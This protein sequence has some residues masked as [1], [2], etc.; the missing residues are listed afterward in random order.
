MLK[1]VCLNLQEAKDTHDLA[2]RHPR[3]RLEQIEEPR[4]VLLQVQL[5]LE[6]LEAGTGKLPNVLETRVCYLFELVYFLEEHVHIF[7]ALVE[8]RVLW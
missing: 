1:V 3:H 7:D 4:D 5:H 8:E 6:R 2:Q